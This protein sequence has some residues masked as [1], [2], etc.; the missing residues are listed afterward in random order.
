MKEHRE[1]GG[2][3]SIDVS[4]QYLRFFLDDDN[5]LEDLRRVSVFATAITCRKV[6][7]NVPLVFLLALLIR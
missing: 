3:C 6:A 1:N 2:D 5:K 4:Y 7:G